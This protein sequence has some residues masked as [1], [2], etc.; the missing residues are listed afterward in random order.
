M[1]IGT[2]CLTFDNMGLAKAVGDGV[3]SAPRPDHPDLTVGYPRTLDLL[4]R[5]G[6]KASFF[7]E[8]WNALHHPDIVKGIAA[9]GHD[10]GMHGF[11]HEKFATLDRHQAER[12]IH[13][14]TAAFRLIGISPVGFRAPGGVRSP[15]MEGPL[16]A[17]GYIY[18]SSVGQD[19]TS[20]IEQTDGVVLLEPTILPSGLVNIPWRWHVI[21]AIQYVPR[22]GGPTSL[23]S[24][25]AYEALVTRL[26]DRTAEAGC[27]LTLILHAHASAIDD[28]RFAAMTRILTHAARHPGLRVTTARA[29]A[30]ET[31]QKRSTPS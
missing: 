12:V 4:D 29:L 13:D 1:R 18:D 2:L 27:T 5:L 30:E 22:P 16:T 28:E 21:D 3:A 11:V 6:L 24:P 7:I 25:S 23:L 8:G 9:R 15:F 19:F 14:A 26:I 31:L 20:P 17:L 10:V